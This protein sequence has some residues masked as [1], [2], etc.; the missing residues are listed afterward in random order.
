MPVEKG[1]SFDISWGSLWK[2]AIMALLGALV[3]F[4]S[5]VILAVI[6]AIVVSA[7]LDPIVSFLETKRIPRVLGTLAIFIA[8]V[9][10]LALVLYTV[11]PIALSELNILLNQ[12]TEFD[13]PFLGFQEF[14]GL[15]KTLNEGIGRLANLL[16][17]GSASLFEA[18]SRFLG[19]VALA[20]AIFVLS[21]YLT[22]DRDGIEKFLQAI[23]PPAYEDR[24]LDIY[25]RTRKKIGRWLQGQIF[26]SLTVGVSVFVALWLMGVKY[27][28]ILGILTGLMEIVPFVGPVFSGAIAFLIA[29]SQSFTSAIYV[30]ILFVLI[31]QLENHLL[32]PTFMRLAIGLNPA[33]ILISLLIGGRIFGFVGLILA[34]PASVLVQE[35]INY[36]SDTKSKRK[37]AMQSS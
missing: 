6:L 3:Y 12:L 7:A 2:V 29:L 14:S 27:S 30:L 18:V 8:V 25:F 23:L 4:A 31:Q 36:W 26:L 32:V 9:V 24:V 33:M 34:V 1:N 13:A 21:F 11:V 22:V 37:A 15:V 35:I 17:S 10:G 28:L 20:I 5:E 19:S 16:I